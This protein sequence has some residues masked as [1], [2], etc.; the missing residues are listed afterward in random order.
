MI[1]LPF[2][3]GLTVGGMISFS[4]PLHH[5]RFHPV[6]KQPMR[7]TRREL[8]SAEVELLEDGYHASGN[9]GPHQTPRDPITQMAL[10]GFVWWKHV[11]MIANPQ[12]VSIARPQ[13]CPD[14]RGPNQEGS[15]EFVVDPKIVFATEND[16]ETDSRSHK[17]AKKAVHR[18]TDP[19]CAS[20]HLPVLRLE[21][22]VRCVN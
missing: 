10:F 6:C 14:A 12:T 18:P 1:G 7:Q 5:D 16:N 13:T 21:G 19:I 2:V 20:F 4:A 11:V 3:C 22:A 9:A 15:D 8:A 17:Q